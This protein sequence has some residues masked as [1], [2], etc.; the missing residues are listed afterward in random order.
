MDIEEIEVSRKLLQKA[1]EAGIQRL[2]RFDIFGFPVEKLR[3]V[4]RETNKCLIGKWSLNSH[5]T[6]CGC[7]ATLADVHGIEGAGYFA[8]GFDTYMKTS[9]GLD[10]SAEAFRAIIKD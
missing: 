2:N 6:S 10:G 7:P 1:I 3:K 4:G 5:S 9:L 8:V